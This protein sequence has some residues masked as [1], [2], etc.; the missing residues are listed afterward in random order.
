MKAQRKK[1]SV[2]KSIRYKEIEKQI[3]KEYRKSQSP[4][5]RHQLDLGTISNIATTGGSGEPLGETF[6]R[7][8]KKAS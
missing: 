4:E 3:K 5:Y 1:T 7:R 8:K 6:S 2:P